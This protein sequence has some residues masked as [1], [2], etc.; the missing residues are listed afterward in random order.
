MHITTLQTSKNLTREVM[1]PNRS[2]R[3]KLGN[4]S[5]ADY[6]HS[7]TCSFYLKLASLL[8]RHFAGCTYKHFFF[9]T[10]ALI[11][12]HFQ[13][14]RLLSINSVGILEIF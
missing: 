11:I 1:T 10:I 4:L 6:Q 14:L 5:S 2:L 7:N 12:V 8:L 3:A 13:N 9:S